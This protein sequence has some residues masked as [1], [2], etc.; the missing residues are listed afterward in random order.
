M[1][2]DI[3]K[4]IKAILYISGMIM[5]SWFLIYEVF[6]NPSYVM[7]TPALIFAM[8]LLFMGIGNGN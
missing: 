1:K 7:D 2:D 4:V 8:G 6:I 3:I 5:I